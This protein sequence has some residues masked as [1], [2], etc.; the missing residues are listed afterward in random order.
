MAWAAIPA[1]LRTRFNTNEILTSLMLT[2]VALLVLGYLIHGPW[3][4]PEGFNF[5]QSRLFHDSAVLP[6]LVAGTRLH[7]GWLV[8]LAAVALAWVVMARHIIGFQVRVVGLRS[9]DHTSALQSL[10]RT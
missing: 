10:M 3:K 7:I 6:V 9:E 1:F 5:P 2:Y 8:A 4:D